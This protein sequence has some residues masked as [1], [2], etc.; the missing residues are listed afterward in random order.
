MSKELSESICISRASQ[1]LAVSFRT[2][3]PQHTLSVGVLGPYPPLSAFLT[4]AP[5]CPLV[6]HARFTFLQSP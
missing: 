4:L 6:A 5:S 2:G 1:C 3:P